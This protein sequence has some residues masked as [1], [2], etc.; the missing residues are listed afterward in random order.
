MEKRVWSIPP[1]HNKNLLGQ[2]FNFV[3][4]PGGATFSWKNENQQNV[5]FNHKSAP[6]HD[7][8]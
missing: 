7:S 4:A 3:S 1:P 5:H 2:K 8:V 6:K